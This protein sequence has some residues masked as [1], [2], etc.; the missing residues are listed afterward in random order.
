[1]DHAV[2]GIFEIILAATRPQIPVS[3]PVGLQ[4]SVCC[5]YEGITANIKLSVLVQERFFHVLL[6]DIAAPMPVN[7][8]SLNQTFDVG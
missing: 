4:V 5:L 1:M 3:V 7:L 6:N 2:C 8:L